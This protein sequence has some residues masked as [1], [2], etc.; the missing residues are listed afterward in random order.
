MGLAVAVFVPEGI[1]LASDGLAE[2][3][4]SETDKGFLLFSL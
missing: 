3:R 4:N 1:V 2:I